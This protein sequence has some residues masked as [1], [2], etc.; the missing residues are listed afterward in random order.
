M[1]FR[2]PKSP[3][4]PEVKQAAPAPTPAAPEVRAAAADARER[5]RLRVGR[6]RSRRTTPGVLSPLTISSASL[7]D[8]LG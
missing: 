7:K 2:K 3:K 6:S 4:I 5:S 1:S 8:T